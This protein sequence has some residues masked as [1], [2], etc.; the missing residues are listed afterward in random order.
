M[1]RITASDCIRNRTEQV[2]G[3]RVVKKVVRSVLRRF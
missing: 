3:I 2:I 1:T